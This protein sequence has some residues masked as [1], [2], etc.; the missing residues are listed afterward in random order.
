MLENSPDKIDRGK[1]CYM[2]AYYL[3]YQA[4]MVR[5]VRE[6]PAAVDGFV[7]EAF[8]E[9]AEHLVKV[10]DPEILEKQAGLMLERVIAEFADV[11]DSFA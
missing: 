11:E 2:L 7:P 8:K 3:R 1:A 9:A 10:A 4:R 5:R 6:Q